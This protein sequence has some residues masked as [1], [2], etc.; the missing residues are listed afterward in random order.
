VDEE[1]FRQ[2]D[3]IP[4]STGICFVHDKGRIYI[5]DRRQ[6]MKYLGLCGAAASV[7]TSG[8]FQPKDRLPNFIIILCDDL[9]YGDLGC[10]GS[11]LHRTPRIDQMAKEGIKLT[12]GLPHVL[13]PESHTGINRDEITLPDLLKKR[14][15]A[16]ACIGKWHLGDQPPFFPTRHGFDSFYGLPYPNAMWPALD[17]G[18]HTKRLHAE[19]NFGP[20]PLMRNEEVI[21]PVT[22]QSFLT[23]ACTKEAIDFI[24]ENYHR[25][26]FIYLPHIAV[27]WPLSPGKEFRG[28]S[29]NGLYGDWVEELDW[30][31]GQILDTLK[32]CGIDEDTLVIFTSDNG[33]SPL[34]NGSVGPLRGRKGN[35]F[36]GGVRPPFIARWPGKIRAGKVCDAVTANWDLMPTIAGLA[37]IDMPDDRI[38]DGRDVWPLLAGDSHAQSPHEVIF[39][40]IG[41]NLMAVRWGYW[42]LHVRVWPKARE[43]VGLPK[44]VRLPLLYNLENDIEEIINV[45]LYYPNIVR[46]LESFAEAARHDLGDGD[47]YPGKNCRPPGRVSHPRLL[48][49]REQ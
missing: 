14:G 45:A 36:E 42:K 26:F 41:V 13:F 23:S 46:K 10:F 39:H 37:G 4:F 33:P 25:S 24:E 1:P 22:E 6:F 5:I 43:Q 17:G 32:R 49:E 8:C 20:L 28:R 15:Y 9:G 35:C 40:Y 7:Y 29:K 12:S 27:H 38:I 21:G 11:R 3:K 31:T 19:H 34:N 44:N 18:E 30:S 48:I 47:K 2:R 16:T